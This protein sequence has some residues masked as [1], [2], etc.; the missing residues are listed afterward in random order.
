MSLIAKRL[1]IKKPIP[2]QRISTKISTMKRESP[3]KNELVRG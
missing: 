2:M 3:E 1:T